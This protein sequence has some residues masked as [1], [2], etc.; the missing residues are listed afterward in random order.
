MTSRSKEVKLAHAQWPHIKKS[1]I[2]GFFDV[3]VWDFKSAKD[4]GNYWGALPTERSIYMQLQAVIEIKHRRAD[5]GI[6]TR[7]WEDDINKLKTALKTRKTRYAYYLVFIDTDDEGN[8]V[9]KFENIRSELR[10]HRS[11]IGQLEIAV[12]SRTNTEDIWI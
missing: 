8:K 2:A 11:K 10:K 5:L 9:P 3:V 7:W 6:S 1:K 12:I 4:V